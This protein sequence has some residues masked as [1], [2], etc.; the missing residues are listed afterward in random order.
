[1]IEGSR[2]VFHALWIIGLALLLAAFSHAQWAAGLHRRSLRKTLWRP[3]CRL[4]MAFGLILF[5][6]GLML[7]ATAWW[8][9][10]AWVGII[11][12]SLW[13]GVAAWRERRGA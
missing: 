13:E 8:L 11:L 1:M 2:L 4:A 3:R 6:L 5:A 12:L 9:R 10:V 7:T